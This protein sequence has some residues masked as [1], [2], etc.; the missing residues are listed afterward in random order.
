MIPRSQKP[1]TGWTPIPSQDVA[2]I[3]LQESLDDHV[4]G[5]HSACFD[6]SAATAFAQQQLDRLGLVGWRIDARSSS[7]TGRLCYG[8][9]SDSAAKTVT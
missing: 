5:L 1:Q 3:E 6:T 2:L 8:G 7:Q 4:N 9:F